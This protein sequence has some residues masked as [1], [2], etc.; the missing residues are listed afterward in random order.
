[1]KKII[2]KL[3]S[4]GGESIGE[5]LIALLISALALMML[6]GAVTAGMR[7]VTNS[8]TVINGYYQVNN[9]VVARA[10]AAPQ[11]NGEDAKT[12]N[13]SFTGTISITASGIV[14]STTSVSAT[15][16]KNDQLNAPVIAYQINPT[17]T[18]TPGA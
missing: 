3:S 9:A 10:T 2:R 11:I 1:M 13:G 14:P 18:P 5:T 8:K 6:A 12:T 4:Q 15:Y 17:P 16:W 7:M